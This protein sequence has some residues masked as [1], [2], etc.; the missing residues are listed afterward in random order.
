MSLI[1][2]ATN[3]HFDIFNATSDIQIYS[4]FT[5]LPTTILKIL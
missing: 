3:F 4:I 1:A 2:M 5:D